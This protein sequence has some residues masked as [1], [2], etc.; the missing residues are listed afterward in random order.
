MI[1]NTQSAPEI[2]ELIASWKQYITTM[3]DWEEVVKNVLP[4]ETYCGPVYELT[5]PLDRPNES[6]AIADMRAI[7]VAEPHYHANGE[8]E[9]YFIISG[10][11]L[12]VVG[13]K[14]LEI[15]VGDVIVTPPQTA[16][17]TIPKDDLV[18]VVINTPPFNP[19]NNMHVDETKPEV[20]YD[21]EQYITLTS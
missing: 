12:T 7:Q 21:H 10:T 2:D 11:G 8:T 13:G 16:H 18:M 9:V 15:R 6:F 3:G 4:K 14:E 1:Y 19:A 17:F 20:G 5:G